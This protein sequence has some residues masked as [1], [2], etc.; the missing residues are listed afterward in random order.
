MIDGQLL[1]QSV[2]QRTASP[3]AETLVSHLL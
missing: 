3:V 1:D 2:L